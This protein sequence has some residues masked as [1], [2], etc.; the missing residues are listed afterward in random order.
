MILGYPGDLLV[1]LLEGRDPI[2]AVTRSIPPGGSLIFFALENFVR[3]AAVVY[4]LWVIW[5]MR[6]QL[7]RAEGAISSLLPEG[8]E[9]YHRAF[10]S[11]SSFLQPAVIGMVVLASFIPFLSLDGLIRTSGLFRLIFDFIV[12]F[13]VVATFG[14]LL[15]VYLSAFRGIH[16]LGRMSLKTKPFYEDPMLGLRVCTQMVPQSLSI[17]A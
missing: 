17:Y 14:S 2:E 5:Y 13:F 9:T 6:M 12:L 8:E 1:E 11:V 4:I 7:V 3:G 10:G 16:F 15:C